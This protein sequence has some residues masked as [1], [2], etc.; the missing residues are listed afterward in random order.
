[1]IFFG[2]ILIGRPKK[3]IFFGNIYFLSQDTV[4]R[5]SVPLRNL[6]TVYRFPRFIDLENL[7]LLRS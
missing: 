5:P 3:T 2:N 1:M 4:N 6:I 7:F